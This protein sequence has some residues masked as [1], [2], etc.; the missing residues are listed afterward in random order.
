MLYIEEAQ[1][2]IDEIDKT[3]DEL[4]SEITKPELSD[5]DKEELQNQWQGK[6][7]SLIHTFY[8]LLNFSA[9]SGEFVV[10]TDTF[11][12]SCD[13]LITKAQAII[14]QDATGRDSISQLLYV[15]SRVLSRDVESYKSVVHIFHKSINN[16]RKKIID[17]QLENKS[18]DIADDSLKNLSLVFGNNLFLVFSDNELYFSHDLLQSLVRVR[19]WLEEKSSEAE[20]SQGELYLKILIEKANFL[21]SKFYYIKDENHKLSDLVRYYKS[22][23]CDVYAQH[24]YNYL[25]QFF[26]QMS[27]VYDEEP[28]YFENIKTYYNI[29]RLKEKTERTYFDYFILCHYYKNIAKNNSLLVDL[30]NDFRLLGGQQ[31][32][33]FDKRSFN[34]T[35]NYLNNCLL[36]SN[37]NSSD[38]EVGLQLVQIEQYFLTYTTLQEQTNVDNFFPFNK[39]AEWCS[40]VITKCLEECKKSTHS[41]LDDVLIHRLISCMEINLEKAKTLLQ[42]SKWSAGCFIPFRPDFKGCLSSV[43]VGTDETLN[44]FLSTAFIVPIDYDTRNGKIKELEANLVRYKSTLESFLTSKRYTEEKLLEVNRIL[45]AHKI[46]LKEDFNLSAKVIKSDVGEELKNAQRSNIQIL[47]IFAAIVIF[48][49]STIQ[50]FT[51]TETVRDAAIFMLMFALSIAALFML[52]WCIF[53]VHSVSK[54]IEDTA[55]KIKTNKIAIG[56]IVVTCLFALAMNIF[57]IFTDWGKTGMHNENHASE[58][59]NTTIIDHK[60]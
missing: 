41:E 58:K 54:S 60:Y 27:S 33:T 20:I 59:P 22:T 38:S 57:A 31:E 17:I 32:S 56:I 29:S 2:L 49:S 23:D 37:L 11:N 55:I 1:T 48:A 36:S 39:I 9:L 15:V 18:G 47:S 45:D 6:V 35:L 4:N 14:N 52:I 24:K 42:S 44:I 28:R 26:E 12:D 10:D 19:D 50:I 5:R 16:P 30:I 25:G 8:K 13:Q 40:D 43:D 7:N 21:I 51:Q 3:I 34:T 46:N 53:H